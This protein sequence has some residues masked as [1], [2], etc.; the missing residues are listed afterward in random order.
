M[1]AFICV[2]T[3]DISFVQ[4]ESRV[5]SKKTPFPWPSLAVKPPIRH[6]APSATLSFIYIHQNIQV[7]MQCWRLML[8]KVDQDQ[9]IIDKDFLF[10]ACLS[11]LLGF[12]RIFPQFLCSNIGAWCS[13]RIGR[14]YRSSY[15][16]FLWLQIQDQLFNQHKLHLFLQ[17]RDCN[18]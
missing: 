14:C 15:W 12:T 13:H 11:N 3:I 18:Q 16:R 2:R 5:G 17:R 6:E 7:F 9:F 8:H 10:S 1:G 4:F